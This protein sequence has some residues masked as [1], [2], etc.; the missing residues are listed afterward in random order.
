MVREVI[1]ETAAGQALFQRPRLAAAAVLVVGAV[2]LSP[3]L[4]RAFHLLNL[5]LL[6]VPLGAAA[7]GLALWSAHVEDRRWGAVLAVVAGAVTL[8]NA[9][10]WYVTWLE[11]Q[12]T[13]DGFMEGFHMTPPGSP[14]G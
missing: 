10:A 6:S 12:R 8:V 5:T 11:F 4:P 3:A 13:F 9:A 7:T 2:A 1:S 14:R